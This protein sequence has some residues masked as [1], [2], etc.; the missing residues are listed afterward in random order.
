MPVPHHVDVT[1]VPGDDW[2]IPGALT[3]FNNNPLDLTTCTFVWVLLGTDGSTLS[4][5]ASVTANSPPTSGLITISIDK[6]VTATLTPGRYSD[7]L[8]VINAGLDQTVWIGY[9]LVDADP[10]YATDQPTLF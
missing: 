3:D 6:A 9:I 2:V 4:A 5:T 10:F 1:L 7:A 8:R